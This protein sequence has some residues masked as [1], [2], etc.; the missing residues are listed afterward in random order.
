VPDVEI[1]FVQTPQEFEAANPGLVGSG[2]PAPCSLFA[3][4]SH[5]DAAD[6]WLTGFLDAG[7]RDDGRIEDDIYISRAATSPDGVV[8]SY[9]AAKEGTTSSQ[10]TQFLTYTR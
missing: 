2:A 9:Q 10:I 1:S 3:D 4:G 8:A 6:A 7:W 5:I